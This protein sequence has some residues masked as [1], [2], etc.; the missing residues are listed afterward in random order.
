MLNK[1]ILIGRLTRTPEIKIIPTG[2]QVASFTVAVNRRYKDKNGNW[3]EDVYFFDIETFGKLA[4][5][6]AQQLDKGYQILIEGE[7]RQDKW[8]SAAGEKR[9]RVKIVANKIS[10][11][12]K[13]ADTN[14]IDKNQTED[15]SNIDFDDDEEEDIPF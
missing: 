7:L 11:L 2:T 6:V 14:N 15:S 13:P 3:Q 9:S 10:L 12:S 1:V 8:E 5:K 4:E